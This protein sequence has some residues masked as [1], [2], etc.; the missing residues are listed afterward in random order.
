[1]T[2]QA[3]KPSTLY[4]PTQHDA[5]VRTFAMT[6]SGCRLTRA[7][8]P[9]Y[10]QLLAILRESI[11]S[12]SPPVGT[13]LPR[14]ADLAESFRVSLITVRQALRDLEAEGFIKKRAAKP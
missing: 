8:G 6:V 2:Q 13:P 12:G 9:L 4:Q 3:A 1:M 10:K 5:N 11:V 14:E 7:G